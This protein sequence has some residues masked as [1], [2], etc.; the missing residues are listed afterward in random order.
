MC[1][2]TGENVWKN[3]IELQHHTNLVCP[4]LVQIH[5]PKPVFSYL[6]GC[7]WVNEFEASETPQTLNLPHFF[8]VPENSHYTS[9][10]QMLYDLSGGSNW[11]VPSSS[12]DFKYFLYFMFHLQS[13]QWC[14]PQYHV[15]LPEENSGCAKS[16]ITTWHKTLPGSDNKLKILLHEYIHHGIAMKRECYVFAQ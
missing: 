11:C 16:Q 12:W 14:T 6:L 2:Q 9:L 5:S 13:F 4:N 3:Q 10:L 15:P 8:L 1:F 7:Y